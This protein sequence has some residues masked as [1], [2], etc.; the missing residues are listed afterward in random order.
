MKNYKLSVLLIVML[1]FNACEKSK[2]EGV[3]KI[4]FDRDMCVQCRMVVSDRHYV[5]QIVDTRNDKAYTF[6]DIGCALLWIAQNPKDW[7]RDAKIYIAESQ[8][9][10]FID[11]KAAY[12]TTGHTTPM[13]FGLA[14]HEKIQKGSIKFSQLHTHVVASQKAHRKGDHE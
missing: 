14:A 4:H 2:T 8:T 6:D 12:W 7:H 10:R 5:A 3:H 13:G 11:A 9:G 1:S